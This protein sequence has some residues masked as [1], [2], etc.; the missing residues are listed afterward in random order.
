MLYQFFVMKIF[1]KGLIIIV[2]FAQCTTLY[3]QQKKYTLEEIIT[4][5]RERSPAS[6]QSKTRKENRYW[7]YRFFKSNYNPQL[8]LSG[9]LPNYQQATTGVTQPDGTIA[10]QSVNQTNTYGNL[11]LQQ[12]ISWT[13]GTLAF[14]SYL[15][16]YNNRSLN[17]KAWNG[18][19][20]SVQL[21][22]PLFAFNQL[23]WDRMTEPLKYEE[24][25]RAN[26]EELEFISRSIVEKYFAVLDAQVNLQIAESNLTSTEIVFSM[27]QDRFNLGTTTREKLLQARLQFLK[28][29]QDI[30]QAKINI[31]NSKLE[32]QYYL[33]YND[34]ADF[35]L[36]LPTN[37]PDLQIDDVEALK[38][39]KANR[40]DYLAFERRKIEAEREVAQAKGQLFQTSLTASFGL[41]NSGTELNDVY[42]DPLQQ[43]IVNLTFNIPIVDWGRNRARMQTA[44]ANKRLNDYTIAIDEKNFEREIINQVSQ[45]VVLLNQIS[46]TKES[47]EVALERYT[48]S[49]EKYLIGKMDITNLN[50]ALAEKDNA[51]RSYVSAIKAFWVAYYDLRRLTLYDFKENKLLYESN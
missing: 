10:F 37:I 48:L 1:L 50:I 40:A 33:G 34:V 4:I 51:T 29:K 12:P 14:N 19:P 38:L 20:V 8:R 18:G 31:K 26:V 24:S 7:Q 13:G 23:R 16:Y 44:M 36:E 27:E 43:Q 5:A 32:F 35:E 41:N 25:K 3:G 15:S 9:D 49:K 22:Q 46:I 11:S 30:I 45:F 21:I 42:T 47:N 17:S 28:S 6:A 2:F 39:A